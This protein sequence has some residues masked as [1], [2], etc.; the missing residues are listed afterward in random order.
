M[1][2]TLFMLNGSEVK[3]L[4][5]SCRGRAIALSHDP[6]LFSKNMLNSIYNKLIPP[7]M[8]DASENIEKLE[9][10]LHYLADRL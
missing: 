1:G 10:Q 8:A 9:E 7:F 2:G 5:L 6:F 3:N 4:A